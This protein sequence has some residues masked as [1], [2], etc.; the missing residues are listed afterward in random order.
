M[1]RTIH[2]DGVKGLR[3]LVRIIFCFAG[4]LMIIMLLLMLFP[5]ER[6][7]LLSTFLAVLFW[8]L[9]VFLVLLLYLLVTD[10]KAARKKRRQALTRRKKPLARH[11]Q[12]LPDR[13]D[14]SRNRR[15]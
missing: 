12:A 14:G 11:R 6:Y 15:I 2:K 1:P 13:K 8:I 3:K 5:R 4:L 9:L 7:W 10:L